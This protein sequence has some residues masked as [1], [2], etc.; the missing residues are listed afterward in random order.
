MKRFALVG[1]IVA[2]LWMP[3]A[4]AVW[5]DEVVV[6]PAVES[7]EPAIINHPATGWD[8][9]KSVVGYLEPGADVVYTF[10]DGRPFQGLS[11]ALYTF[12]SKGFPLASARGGYGV[13][14]PVTYGS[15]ALDLPGL[16]G[17][18]IPASVKGVS[19]GALNGALAFA[20]KYIRIG[21]T[22]GFDWSTNKM[23]WGVSAGAAFTT[24]F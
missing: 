24:S 23:R 17:R 4:Q 16:A 10:N 3:L 12:K 1:L 2:G 19:P 15:L 8:L 6:E 9:T 7:A 18:F 11:G 21:P 13:T 22:G 20:A 14:D 5:A